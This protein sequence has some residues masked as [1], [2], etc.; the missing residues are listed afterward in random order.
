MAAASMDG[1]PSMKHF[2]LNP[3][4]EVLRTQFF[5]RRSSRLELR[6]KYDAARPRSSDLDRVTLCKSKSGRKVIPTAMC[7]VSERAFEIEGPDTTHN[8]RTRVEIQRRKAD[9][10]TLVACGWTIA[11][12]T[13]THVMLPFSL[14]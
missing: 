9:T 1:E 11:A 5:V 7:A 10:P 8:R 2:A 4:H 6:T 3:S 12:S 14:Q 13:W